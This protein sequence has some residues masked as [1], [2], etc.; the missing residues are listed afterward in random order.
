MGLGDKMKETVGK[1]K[2][3]IGDATD[4]E[5]LRRSGQKD[6]IEANVSEVGH[7][8]DEKV[9]DASGTVADKVEDFKDSVT[10]DR[11]H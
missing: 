10:D 7:K 5:E 11:R 8:V 2:E 4:N 3:G 1:A 9:G 6:R